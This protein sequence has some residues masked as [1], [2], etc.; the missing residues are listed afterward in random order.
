[1]VLIIV[2]TTAAQQASVLVSDAFKEDQR[3]LSSTRMHWNRAY[4]NSK[5]VFLAAC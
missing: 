4:Y 3:R 2:Q 5:N 1:M